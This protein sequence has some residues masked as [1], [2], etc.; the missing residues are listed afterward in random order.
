MAKQIRLECIAKVKDK[1]Y[2]ILYHAANGKE[3]KKPLG[4]TISHPDHF[5]DGQFT[6]K[7][8]RDHLKDY[9]ELNKWLQQEKNRINLLIQQAY[10]MNTDSVEYIKKH[11]DDTF[12]DN[13]KVIVEENTTIYEAFI[14]YI[15][16]KYNQ[17][18]NNI[19][20]NSLERYKSFSKRLKDYDDKT[21]LSNFDYDW[22]AH[23]VK[24]LSK[25]KVKTLNIKDEKY[26]RDYKAT[27]T[28]KQ[29]N[30]TI[31]RGVQDL[32]TFC[33][34]INKKYPTIEF[35]IQRMEKLRKSLSTNDKDKRNIV[36]MTKEELD[37]FRALRPSL[38]HQWQIDCWCAYMIGALTGLRY[39]DI[40][41]LSNTHIRK[42]LISNRT[43]EYIHLNM[44]KTQ[45]W[46]KIPLH[47]E[48]KEILN[49]YGGSMVGKVPTVQ[50]LNINLRKLLEK[51]S[52]FQ[53]IEKEVKFILFEKFDIDKKR[54]KR[55]TFHTSR[56]TFITN[57]VK[58]NCTYNQII[59][60]VGFQDNRTIQS[61][62][63]SNKPD[64]NDFVILNF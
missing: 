45:I 27:K 62:I 2:V 26:E 19:K 37:A 9:K 46:V 64:E 5:K 61:Y 4:V 31:K 41:L 60:F 50:R 43:V 15:S 3:Y 33:K 30:S 40:R 13:Q 55:F 44:V 57:C 16:V 6:P 32:I 24:W 48:V 20:D 21:T 54:F 52:I 18:L 23:F 34:T 35:P 63:D 22:V 7:Y 10:S 56:K 58:Q 25:P 59:Q 42:E 17:P 29:S 38:K 49:Y 8:G 11:L 28:F 39:S 12:K 51:I 1:R 14:N 53:V 36:A 47:P